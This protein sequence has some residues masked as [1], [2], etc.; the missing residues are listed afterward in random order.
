MILA[1]CFILTLS[2]VQDD[3]FPGFQALPSPEI[4]QEIIPIPPSRWEPASEPVLWA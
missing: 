2:S 4:K 1:L 3:F